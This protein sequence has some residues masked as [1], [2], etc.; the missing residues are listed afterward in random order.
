MGHN[1]SSDKR[2]THSSKS[3]QRENEES[4]HWQLDSTPESSRTKGSKYGLEE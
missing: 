3:L 1:K 2:E 4:I